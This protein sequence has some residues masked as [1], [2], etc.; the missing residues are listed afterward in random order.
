MGEPAA[1]GSEHVNWF[2]RVSQEQCPE[3]R[4]HCIR[5]DAPMKS[6]GFPFWRM[7]LAVALGTLLA[8]AIAAAVGLLWLNMAADE[9]A[10]VLDEEL[11][12]MEAKRVV[13]EQERQ[14]EPH[15]R[16]EQQAAA[17]AKGDRRP[18]LPQG[19]DA[20]TTGSTACM[21]GYKSIK[22]ADGRWQQLLAGGQAQPCRTN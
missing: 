17:E 22:L 10:R 13:A 7:V 11:R 16:R 9:A 14:H 21:Y 3:D 19:T 6:D 1:T 8:G 4:L 18:L 12:E 20:M 5:P 15:V 2:D